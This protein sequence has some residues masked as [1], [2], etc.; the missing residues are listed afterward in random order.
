MTAPLRTAGQ[1]L[2]EAGFGQ[3]RVDK[4]NFPEYPDLDAQLQALRKLDPRARE[5]NWIEYALGRARE[6]RLADDPKREAAELA[7]ARKAV[8]Q[9]FQRRTPPGQWSKM[10]VVLAALALIGV[11]LWLDRRKKNRRRRQNVPLEDDPYDP[12][13]DPHGLPYQGDNQEG[14]DSEDEDDA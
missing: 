9:S 13:N 1:F 14:E 4:L 10:A 6:A 11:L 12:H 8:E 2:A 3:Y 5:I 7:V